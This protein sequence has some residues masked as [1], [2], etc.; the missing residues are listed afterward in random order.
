MFLNDLAALCGSTALHFAM[1]N[2]QWETADFL[3]DR[4]ANPSIRNEGNYRAV[5]YCT[6]AKL[7][8]RL[9]AYMQKV[10]MEV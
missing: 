8:A 9:T 4:G 6:N 7:K 3:I 1:L 10:R 2:K 5:D